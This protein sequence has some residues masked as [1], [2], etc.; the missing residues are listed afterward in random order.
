MSAA[1]ANDGIIGLAGAGGLYY[2]SIDQS[3]TQ[4]MLADALFKKGFAE[5]D[6]APWY[7]CGKSEGDLGKSLTALTRYHHENNSNADDAVCEGYLSVNSDAEIRFSNGCGMG[8]APPPVKVRTLQI[9]TAGGNISSSSSS[10]LRVGTKC[11]RVTLPKTI[12]PMLEGLATAG[13][14]SAVFPPSDVLAAAHLTFAAVPTVA[15]QYCRGAWGEALSSSSSALTIAYRR[16]RAGGVAHRMRASLRGAEAAKLEGETNNKLSG[17][18]GERTTTPTCSSP[19][20]TNS[21]SV[22][23]VDGNGGVDADR[24][25]GTVYLAAHETAHLVCVHDCTYRGVLLGFAQSYERIYGR[26]HEAI[27]ERVV[28]DEVSCLVRI[29]KKTKSGD[30]NASSSCPWFVMDTLR[31]HDADQPHLFEE[32]MGRAN[33]ADAIIGGSSS[34]DDVADPGGIAAMKYL[35]SRGYVLHLSLGMNDAAYMLK[36]L[37]ECSLRV[38]ASDAHHRTTRVS[39]FSNVMLAGCWN[40]IFRD[41]AH[42]LPFFD[43]MRT[44]GVSRKTLPQLVL[45]GGEVVPQILPHLSCGNGGSAT[46][47]TESDVLPIVLEN[48]GIFGAGLLW[49]AAVYRYEVAKGALIAQRDALSKRIDEAVAKTTERTDSD[50]T[51]AANPSRY[52]LAGAA[53]T[54]AAEDDEALKGIPTRLVLGCVSSHELNETMIAMAHKPSMAI[55]RAAMV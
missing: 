48:A 34:G 16:A 26:L 30:E 41:E 50:A 19:D 39:P 14:D 33:G 18:L 11:G 20:A 51:Y 25:T 1:K 24:V 10:V 27:G 4:A 49:G 32:A 23:A 40:L 46:E 17:V 31:L 37:R 45:G 5:V 8:G 21:A 2:K 12:I 36:F 43:C 53:I 35:Q 42:A 9:H 44:L 29:E 54:F 28:L 47:G 13:G 22:P 15:S 6:T 38:S 55:V 3:Q 52:N 7:G